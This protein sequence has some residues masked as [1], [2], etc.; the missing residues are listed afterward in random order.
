MSLSDTQSS[1][2]LERKKCAGAR[3]F[4]GP[5][6][7]PPPPF[8]TLVIYVDDIR[9]NVEIALLARCY[10]TMDSRSRLMLLRGNFS[11]TAMH[12]PRVNNPVR[13]PAPGYT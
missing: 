6:A 3:P 11:R 10:L 9:P 12:L 7:P 4:A 1:S 2:A 5:S 8:P 13:T